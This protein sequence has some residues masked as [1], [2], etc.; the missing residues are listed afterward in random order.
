MIK[1]ID[2][3]TIPQP[4]LYSI[5]STAVAPRPIC[6]ASTVDKEGNVNLSPFSFFNVFSSNPP[7]M[8]F[9][10][11]RSGRDN[12][13]K[14]THQNVV[15]VPEVVINIVNHKMVEQMSLSSTAYNKGVNE[16]VK[17]GFTEV[18]S[19]KVK[20]PR[21]GEAPVSFEC[22][23]LEV[24]ELAQTPGAGNLIMA[25]VDMI[26]IN[27]EYLTDNVLDTEKLDLVG[28]M[29]GNWYIRA[30][31]ESLFEI[32]KPIRTHGIGV[33]ALP[34]GIRESE[35]LTGNNLGRLGNLESLP[36][37]KEVKTIIANEGVENASKTELHSL[38]KQLLEDGDTVKAMAYLLFAENL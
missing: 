15:E 13:L 36:S 23:V 9:S 33:D 6:F 11:T 7:V 34:K 3:T 10:P 5:L 30:I 21:V 31:R 4:E 27:D 19:V 29:G 25:Q 2:P 16:F 20:P 37:T 28:R 12:S 26:H 38:A 32:P 8:V 18:P 17:A 14:H 24:V 35:V 22:T 1:T